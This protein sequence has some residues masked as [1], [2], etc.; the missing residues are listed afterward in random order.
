MQIQDLRDLAYLVAAVLFIIDL[1]WMAH[2][3][4]AVRGN[5]VG[6]LGMA[7]AIAA[8][9]LGQSMTWKYI[10]IGAGVGTII[11]WLMATKVKVTSMPEMVGILNG[12]GGGASVLVGCSALL[13][14]YQMLVASPGMGMQEKV[15]TSASAIIGA[16]TF[17]GSYVAFAKLAEFLGVKWKLKPWQTWVKYG[18][19]AATG[20]GGLAYALTVHL[21]AAASRNDRLLAWAT[22][23]SF[24]CTAW[25]LKERI[26]PPIYWKAMLKGREWLAKPVLAEPASKTAV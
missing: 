26:L 17:F 16:V 24:A 6:A 11:G 8:T 13:A 5:Y 3:K 25:L 21:S 22:F 2:P 15:A 4:T 12:F 7:I 14:A 9:V 1:K 19:A 20:V 10:L 18:F 23:V